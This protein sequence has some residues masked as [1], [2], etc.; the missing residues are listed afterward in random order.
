MNIAE[1]IIEKFGGT[2][3]L[4]K[5]TGWK[6]STIQSWKTAGHIP[7]KRHLHLLDIAAD[8]GVDLKPADFYETGETA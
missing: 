6:P 4:A 1:R 2:R 5:K 7:F 3:P 8:H